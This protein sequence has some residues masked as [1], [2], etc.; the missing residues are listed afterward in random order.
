MPAPE[1]PQ[2]NTEATTPDPEKINIYDPCNLDGSSDETATCHTLGKIESGGKYTA[3]NPDT[4]ASGRY[5]FTKKTGKYVMQKAGLASNSSEAQALWDECAK[6]SSAKCKGVQDKMCHWYSNSI[7]SQLKKK[8]VP[9]TVA[10]MYFAWNQG[11][12]GMAIINDAGNGEVTDP[13]I[14]NKM[15]KQAW[16]KQNTTYNGKEFIDRMNKWVENDRGVKADTII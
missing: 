3:K 14:R 7:K 6:S 11:V 2:E 15:A 1:N 4:S 5:Q 8:G 9:L 10:N 16:N 13:S 12:G